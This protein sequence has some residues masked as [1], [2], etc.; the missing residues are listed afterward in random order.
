MEFELNE[1]QKMI[2]QM[3]KDLGEKEIKPKLMEWDES[4]TLP[5]ELLKD[6]MG[7]LGLLG[8]LV[9]QEYGGAG[10]GYFE[11]VTAIS[12]IGKVCGSIGL[13]VAA[14]NS[15][16]SGH[17]NQFANDEQK[18]KWLSKLAT[19]EWLGAWALTEPNTGSD[20]MRMKCTAVEEG[21]DYI[22]NGTKTWITHG[23]SSDVVVAIVRTGELLDSRGMTAFVIERGTPGLKA[24][25]KEDKLGMRSS[26]TT[27][28]IFED[29]RVPKANILGQVGEGFIQAMKVLDGG[30][31]SIAALGLGIAKGALMQ[32]FNT[33]RKGSNSVSQ[34]QIS[35]E[36]PLNWPIW[37]LK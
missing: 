21:D 17:I 37:L 22:I 24:G 5:I 4:Q 13:S 25:K 33:P 28:V 16:C 27:E 15:L 7:P 26:E 31:I 1:N 18:K 19:G 6:K 9:P 14:H 32:V 10:L 30:R 34:F 35:R 36:F 2:A 11:Y 8:I 20:A 3:V 23:K 12:E 29:C